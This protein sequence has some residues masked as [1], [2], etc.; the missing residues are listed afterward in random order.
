MDAENLTN[1]GP[2]L[3][4]K[5]YGCGYWLFILA[6][7]LVWST[8]TALADATLI[9]ALV[10]QLHARDFQEME[11]EVVKCFAREEGQGE[12]QRVFVDIVYAYEINGRRF[13]GMRVRRP[14][15]DD[16]RSRRFVKNHPPGTRVTV[17][18]NADDPSDAVLQRGMDGEPF[19][20]DDRFTSP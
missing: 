9:W 10:E 17:Y 16:A 14:D 5:S 4:P 8:A 11:G 15:L 18:Y 3:K 20:L 6:F 7:T 12:D 19:L 13:S 2:V 1:R